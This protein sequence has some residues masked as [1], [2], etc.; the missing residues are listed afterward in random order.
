MLG[1]AL[2]RLASGSEDNTI[3]IW[4]NVDRKTP[5]HADQIQLK[6]HANSVYQVCWDPT[7]A[8]VLASTSSDKTLRFWDARIGQCTANIEFKY[9]GLHLVWNPDGNNLLCAGKFENMD[10]LVVIDPRINKIKKILKF[11]YPINDLSFNPND[12]SL[13]Y[14]VTGGDIELWGC[15]LK[16]STLKIQK[17][18]QAHNAAQASCVDFAP[19]GK[20]FATGGSDSLVSI[21]DVNEHVCLRTL[22]HLNSPV[23]NLSISHD[24]IYVASSNEDTLTNTCSVDISH[25]ESGENIWTMPNV[26]VTSLAWHPS[27]H[28]LAYSVRERDRHDRETGVIK[29]YGNLV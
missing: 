29:V 7:N 24:S 13:F 18:L 4:S 1:T 26:S 27:K 8:D 19:N 22:D 23:T 6:G 9:E 14:L 20:I 21:W 2:D 28:I 11:F 16:E 10:V 25:I 5:N 3:R 15:N 12:G 17:Q